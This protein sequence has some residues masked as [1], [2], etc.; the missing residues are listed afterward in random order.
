MTIKTKL[1]ILLSLAFVLFT[2]GAWIVSTINTDKINEEWAERFVKKQIVFDKNRTLLPILRE[3]A[4]AKEMSKDPA[5]IQMALHDND[6]LIRQKGIAAL[7]RYRLK[8]SDRS[9]FA[10][11][12]SSRH[13]YFNDYANHYAGKQLGYTLSRTNPD[14]AWFFKAISSDDAYQ[15]NVNKDTVLGITKV[16]INFLLKERGKTVGIIGTGLELDK[17]LKESVDIGQEG[18]RNI[19]V[20]KDLAIQLER[21]T[22]LIDYSSLAKGSG[23][24]QTLGV[25][26]KEKGDIE[27]IKNAMNELESAG[28][29]N[30]V[31]TL[32]IDFEGKKKLIGIAYLKELGWYSLTLIDSSE[33]SIAN[34]MKMFVVLS[35]MFLA[36]MLILSTIF[37][38]AFINPLNTLK[39]MMSRV[40]EGDYNIGMPQ[41]SSGEIADLSRQ[42]DKMVQVIRKNKAELEN[43]VKER[44]AVLRESEQKLN[45]I[46]ES[47]EGY[48]YIKDRDYRYI[49]VNKAV[50]EL[51]GKP[52]IEILGKDDYAFFDKKTASQLRNN[53]ILVIEKGEKVVNEEMS[54]SADGSVTKAFLSIKTPLFKEDGSVYA[55]C[56]IS[57]DITERKHAE[58]EIRHQAFYDT[59]TQLPNRQLLNDRLEQAVA[60]SKRSK[61]YNA[62]L[63]MDLDNFKP[64]NDLY[65]HEVGDL[66]L[67]ET[68]NRLKGCVREMD[69]VSRFGG[70]EFIVLLTGL[71]DKP[72]RAA[73][74]AIFI[75]H[76][77]RRSI[78]EVFTL[79]VTQGEEYTVQH[80][81]TASIGVA[82]FNDNDSKK[83]VLKRA[84]QAMYEAKDAGRNQVRFYEKG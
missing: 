50:R 61:N 22:R 78:E 15:I 3:V 30:G 2:T 46:L 52:E 19:F 27:R 72:G 34:N 76:K 73:E 41:I 75:A 53:D 80:R 42:F 48:I 9:Y 32:W 1:F 33:L 10:A 29:E 12:L 54:S 82:L 51:F 35:V 31:K 36:A 68:A 55:L 84:D 39:A 43:K 74:Y 20:N 11:F 8:Y 38:H 64:L 21:D 77:I 24:H 71:S 67:I 60:V 66:L 79:K 37:N 4:L 28:E 70:D 14:D 18:I 58:E 40:E 16:W 47:V 25:L 23:P 26:F 5:I 7:E 63:F 62:L 81:C 45:A 59:L 69:T 17:F 13:Y 57:T 56:G 65:G 44:T 6:P 49:Y 83:T